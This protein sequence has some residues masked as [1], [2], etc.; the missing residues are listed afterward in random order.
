MSEALVSPTQNIA[1]S[2]I[3]DGVWKL[4]FTTTTGSSG[5]KLGPFVGNVFQDI[6]YSDG[7]YYNILRLGP[8]E[9]VLSAH[10][11]V[12]NN[13]KWDVTFDDIKLD[14]FGLTLVNKEFGS[15]RDQTLETLDTVA[16]GDE[17]ARS[18]TNGGSWDLKYAD[19]S[20][21]VLYAYGTVLHAPPP[22]PPP[23]RTSMRMHTL[24]V[25]ALLVV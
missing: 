16:G 13:D 21:R 8:V 6:R 15:G 9:A 20:L 17:T 23:P 4:I 19:D 10:W 24:R 12:V 5:G 22:T 1:T 7:K 18:S 25:A 3:V 2:P 11:D 14:V